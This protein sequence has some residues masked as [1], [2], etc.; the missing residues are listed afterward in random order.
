MGVLVWV[1]VCSVIWGLHWGTYYA[2]SDGAIQGRIF[3]DI[4]GWHA[5]IKFDFR[6]VQEHYRDYQVA[7]PLRGALIKAAIGFGLIGSKSRGSHLKS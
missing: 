6:D 7:T 4:G 5:L 2:K 3:T 1:V